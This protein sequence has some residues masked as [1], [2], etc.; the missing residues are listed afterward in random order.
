MEKKAG[1]NKTKRA[2]NSRNTKRKHLHP[3]T[4]I[5]RI[6]IEGVKLELRHTRNEKKINITRNYESPFESH[7][8]SKLR[9]K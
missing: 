2:K 6:K 7:E 3:R 8:N 4:Y 1:G 5:D 9:N